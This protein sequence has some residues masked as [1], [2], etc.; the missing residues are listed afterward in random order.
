MS[1][2]EAEL[3]ALSSAARLLIWWKRI[4]ARLPFDIG[5][6]AKILCDNRQAIDLITNDDTPY[7][8][9]FA[10]WTFLIFGFGKVVREKLI[11]IE[12]V[13]TAAMPADGLMKLLP[14][15][16]HDHFVRELG[17]VDLAKIRVQDADRMTAGEVYWT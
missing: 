7:G 12:W 11:K 17:L 8:A 9:S 3:V 4:F 16:K 1:T 15:Q 13:P 5:A 6:E 2:T 14:R 10:T